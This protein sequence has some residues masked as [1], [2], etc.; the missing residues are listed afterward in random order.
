MPGV[1]GKHQQTN[2][3]ISLNV[4]LLVF[5]PTPMPTRNTQQRRDT[6]GEGQ[7]RQKT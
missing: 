1:D 6:P 3:G 2:K 4:V 5:L 7:Q